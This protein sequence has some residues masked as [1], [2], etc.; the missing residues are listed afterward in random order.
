MLSWRKCLILALLAATLLGCARPRQPMAA[1]SDIAQPYRFSFL[2]WELAQFARLLRPVDTPPEAQRDPSGYVQAYLL[3]QA[4]A[5]GLERA[6]EPIP[7]S[8]ANDLAAMRPVAERIVAAQVREAYRQEGIYHPLERYLPLP[9]TFPPV[10]FVFEP[11]PLLLVVSPRERI[12]PIYQVMLT[13]GLDVAAM[14]AIEGR[15]AALGYSALVTEIGGLG[16]TYPAVVSTRSALPRAIE[17]VAEEWLHQYLAFTP[18]GFGYILHLLGL[19]PDYEIAQLNESLATVVH[20]EIAGRV[21]WERYGIA[22]EPDAPAARTD[23]DAFDLRAFMRETRLHAEALLQAN[24]IDEA[25][26]YMEA[27]R[28]ILVAEGYRIRKL[29]Q[30]YFAFHGT[31][32]DAPGAITLVGSEL[33][34]LRAQC[35]SLG[36]FLDLAV[37]LTSREELQQLLA[38]R[39]IRSAHLTPASSYTER[40]AHA[41][42]VP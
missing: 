23:A 24:K 7:P 4:Q 35:A 20:E 3:L 15:I 22:P 28:Q 42:L 37:G 1:L 34:A 10:W 18:L 17:T 33:R 39:G 40:S 14:E 31:Y 12:A 16:A 36:A 41:P 6:G 2:R 19:R 5:Q 38:E 29:N 11:P 9:V 30:A 27:R 26:A 8:L 21:L 32:A 25:E 13:P